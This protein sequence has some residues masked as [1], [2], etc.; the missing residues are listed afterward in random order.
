M[1]PLLQSSKTSYTLIRFLKETSN[2]REI[3]SGQY[4]I[5]YQAAVHHTMLIHVLHGHRGPE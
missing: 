5:K 1:F 2:R 3:A 4:S